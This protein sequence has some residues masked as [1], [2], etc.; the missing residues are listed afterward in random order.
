V[1]TK[2]EKKIIEIAKKV[3]SDESEAIKS[4]INTI[5]QS[6]ANVVQEILEAKGKVV[7]S[8]IGK[9]GIIAQKIS[10]TLNSTGQQAVFMHATDAVHGDLGIIGDNDVIIILS[11]SGNTSELKVLVPLI[12]RLPNTLVAMVSDLDSYLARNSDYVLNAHV[13]QEACPMNLAPTT[14]T[15]VSLALG[16]ALAVC[17]L[18]ARGFTNRDFAKYHPGGS[19]GKKLYLK[20][21]D[22]Y[23]NNEVPVVLESATMEEVIMEISSKRLG[24]TAVVNNEKLLAGVITDGDL[25]RKLREKIDIFALTAKD[26]MSTSP[27]TISKNEYAVNALNKM[28]ELSITQLVVEENGQVLGFVHLHDL[29]KEGLV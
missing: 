16:D 14:S 3:L 8:G 19:L 28:Q 5:D 23:P 27:K 9:S 4:L 11:K 21:S 6:F 22:I 2:V 24:T 15:T 29:L 26:L 20:V 7:L 18:E 25:R 1:E 12:K 13:D 10:A 17:L